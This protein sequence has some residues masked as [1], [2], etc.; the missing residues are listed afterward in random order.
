MNFNLVKLS[1]SGAGATIYAIK[2]VGEKVSLF[3]NFIIENRQDFSN[4]I[5]NIKHRLYTMGKETGARSSFFKLNEGRFGDGVCALY[6]RPN[7]K[8]RL[9]CIRFGSVAVIL[10]GGGPKG[11]AIRAWQEDQKL[12]MEANRAIRIAAEINKA[13]AKGDLIWSKDKSEILE[14]D[15]EEI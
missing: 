1:Y 6:D 13:F 4:E 15:D 8:L 14:Q 3:E 12:S 9:Y 5:A 11:K 2:L 10:C 7:S